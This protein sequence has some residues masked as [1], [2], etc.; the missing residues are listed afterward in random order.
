MSKLRFKPGLSGKAHEIDNLVRLWIL[1]LLVP[2]EGH[3]EFL[4]S[5]SF[6]NDSLAEILGLGEWIDN[7][8]KEYKPHLIRSKLRQ[9]HREAERA[10][11]RPTLW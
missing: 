3:R 9:M 8:K 11:P 5:H 10:L 7:D 1:R 2:L 4:N 6:G